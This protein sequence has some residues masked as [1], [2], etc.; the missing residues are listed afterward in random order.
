MSLI[1]ELT[2]AS[3]SVRLAIRNL[4]LAGPASVASA[5][6]PSTPENDQLWYD[7][8]NSRIMVRVAGAWVE[9]TTDIP[10]MADISGLV[11]ALAGKAGINGEL[12]DSQAFRTALGI[13]PI[14]RYAEQGPPNAALVNSVLVTSADPLV[15]GKTLIFAGSI[16]PESYVWTESG[17]IDSYETVLHLIRTDTPDVLSL[18]TPDGA[19]YA[20]AALT[21]APL[22]PWTDSPLL[23]GGAAATLTEG[24]AL[25]SGEFVGQLCRVGDA[26]PYDW[27][28]WDGAAWDVVVTPETGRLQIGITQM[29]LRVAPPP[30]AG[31]FSENNDYDTRFFP[32]AGL[33]GGRPC[34]T[35]DGL[36][37]EA[38][39]TGKAVGW[40]A[41]D[42]SWVIGEAVAGVFSFTDGFYSYDDVPSI[43]NVTTWLFAAGETIYPLLTEEEMIPRAFRDSPTVAEVSAAIATN[44]ELVRGTVNSFVG[45]YENF[46]RHTNGLL[47]PD[48]TAPEVGGLPW[49]V[50]GSGK[51]VISD[52]GVGCD[53]YGNCYLGSTAACPEG[54]LDAVFE[55]EVRQDTINL[56]VAAKVMTITLTSPTITSAAHGYTNG[57]LVVL[58]TTGIL[59]TGLTNGSVYFI[60]N[61]ATDTFQL[62]LTASGAVITPTGSQSGSHS[63]NFPHL[64]LATAKA[65]TITLN[66][67]TIS[68]TAHGYIEGIRIMLATNDTLPTGLSNNGTVYFVRNPTANAFQLSE[69]A[70]GAIITPTGSQLGA[71]TSNYAYT[72]GLLVPSWSENSRFT[73]SNTGTQ[74]TT[75]G[76]TIIRH[77]TASGGTWNIIHYSPDGVIVYHAT[78]VST[79]ST[80]VGL[81]AWTLV[82]GSGQPTL[83]ARYPSG[84]QGGPGFTFSYK[85]TP[86]F[87]SGG[88]PENTVHV[89]VDAIFPSPARYNPSGSPTL[90]RKTVIGSSAGGAALNRV[91]RYRIWAKGTRLL[92]F[93][94][95]AMWEYEVSDGAAMIGETTY[96]YFQLNRLVWP[97]LDDP[98]VRPYTVL[99]RMWVNAPSHD[100]TSLDLASPMLTGGNVVHPSRLDLRLGNRAFGTPIARHNSGAPLGVGGTSVSDDNVITGTSAFFDGKIQAGVGVSSIWSPGVVP[101]WCSELSR[102]SPLQSPANAVSTTSFIGLFTPWNMIAGS[103]VVQRFSGTFGLTAYN[104]EILVRSSYGMWLTLFTSG[105]TAQSGGLWTLEIRRMVH[106]SFDRTLIFEFWSASTGHI[107]GTYIYNRGSSSTTWDPCALTVVGTALGD[108]T[109]LEN[110]A[111]I[112]QK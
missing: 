77:T 42:A 12:I 61:V 101:V 6:A 100:Q 52:G 48:M 33:Y 11:A 32:C 69:T 43:L 54:V 50:A 17:L 7:T 66:N 13:D 63:S 103:T 75:T 5:T 70:A 15:N 37:L 93:Y 34:W 45:F 60:R 2:T 73:W 89:N 83:F 80:P 21:G 41:V 112:Y 107:G 58:T 92:V 102:T 47:V 105:V 64:S 91:H 88:T 8:V 67:P 38:G 90:T 111:V 25:V 24:T 1:L 108:V 20:N 74:D 65:M 56:V 35:L 28:Q 81:I 27:Y 99:R 57:T 110:T 31:Q 9:V 95:G 104:K 3:S 72:N 78:K 71:H 109:V 76:R 84:N 29:A 51:P 82:V 68:S 22:E 46:S 98:T 18:A 94:P 87:G 53:L 30:I 26:A 16:G 40:S 85:T 49:G 86:N 59:P 36:Q 23:D 10:G 4:L 44:P 62:S 79:T 14:I 19:T 97:G 96:F 106:S 39:Y 55:V